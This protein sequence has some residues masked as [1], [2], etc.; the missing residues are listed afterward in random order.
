MD[1]CWGDC[2]EGHSLQQAQNFE[3]RA[4][5]QCWNS[6][7]L[8]TEVR[9]L[10]RFNLGSSADYRMFSI[11]LKGT[12]LNFYKTSLFNLAAFV[13]VISLQNGK[14]RSLNL[15]AMDFTFL[16]NLIYYHPFQF[17]RL[18]YIADYSHL[19]PGSQPFKIFFKVK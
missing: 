11:E 18:F 6:H 2:P 13:Y 9:K 15:L 14:F 7:W 5:S 12:I 3:G 4:P 19:C 1:I 16:R 8:E 10:I 17:I